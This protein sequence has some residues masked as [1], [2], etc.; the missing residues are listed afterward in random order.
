MRDS[1]KDSAVPD[2]IVPLATAHLSGEGWD[3]TVAVDESQQCRPGRRLQD[4]RVR[5]EIG[6]MMEQVRIQMFG[7]SEITT[8]RPDDSPSVILIVPIRPSFSLE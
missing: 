7:H 8:R 5:A 3:V 4:G 1:V 6:P 2:E